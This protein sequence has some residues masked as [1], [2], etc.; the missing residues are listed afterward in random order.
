M[1]KNKIKINM[2]MSVVLLVSMTIIAC[3]MDKVATVEMEKENKNVKTKN[4]KVVV[5]DP[6]HGGDDPG[7]VGVNGTKEKEVNLAI[8]KCSIINNTYQINS[9]SIMISIHQNSFT[10]PNVKGAQSFFYEKSEKSKKLGLI[11]QNHLNKKI[12]T[13][14]EKAAKPNNSYYMLINSKCPG[15]IIECGFLSNPSE[16]ESLSKEEYQ[17]KLAEII[18]TGI[19]EYFGEK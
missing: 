13:E 19:K 10:N 7:K 4:G 5:I 1:L 12:N 14:K 8:S 15:T 17:K 18:C 16:E 2:V 3:N 6:G 9:N 11:L